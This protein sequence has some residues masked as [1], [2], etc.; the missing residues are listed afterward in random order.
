MEDLKLLVQKYEVD[1]EEFEYIWNNCN[2][3]KLT[4]D[5]DDYKQR[6]Y[7]LYNVKLDDFD[8]THITYEVKYRPDDNRLKIECSIKILSI[9]KDAVCCDMY[10]LKRYITEIDKYNNIYIDERVSDLVNEIV[11]S[12]KKID[13]LKK[14]SYASVKKTVK[15]LDDLICERE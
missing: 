14:E 5:L 6:G 12:S 15:Y 3:C 1:Y 9:L 7:L 11:S 2:S 4:S 10:D 8:K 13:K